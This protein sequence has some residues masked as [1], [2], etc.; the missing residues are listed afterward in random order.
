MAG[1]VQIIEVQTEDIGPLQGHVEEWHR[2]QSGAA[3]GYRSTRVLADGERPGTYLLEVAFSSEEEA[4]K[5]NDRPETARWA[6]RARSLVDGEPSYRNL[7]VV[8]DTG[9]K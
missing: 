8:C 1:F 2:L 9:A 3:P 4:K 5:N 6:D 7:T